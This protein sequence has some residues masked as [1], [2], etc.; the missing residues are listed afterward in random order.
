MSRAYCSVGIIITVSAA[1]LCVF[2]PAPSP[3]F[4][5]RTQQS[6]LTPNVANFAPLRHISTIKRIIN[7]TA[8]ELTRPLPFDIRPAWGNPTL[9]LW[10]P[11]TQQV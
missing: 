6:M 5:P 2:P 7:A 10:A 1:H 8:I 3:H 11:Y 4:S 9:L